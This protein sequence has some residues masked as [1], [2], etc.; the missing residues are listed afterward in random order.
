MNSGL[1]LWRLEF[2]QLGYGRIGNYAKNGTVFQ[3]ISKIGTKNGPKSFRKSAFGENGEYL[4]TAA[5]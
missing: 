3:L 2:N 4:I 5:Q 1:L